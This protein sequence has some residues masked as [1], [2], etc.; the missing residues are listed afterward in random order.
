[1]PVLLDKIIWLHLEYIWHSNTP[2][3]QIYICPERYSFCYTSNVLSWNA[4][5]F[6]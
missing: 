1:L 2:L 6:V 4:F 3:Q 5:V